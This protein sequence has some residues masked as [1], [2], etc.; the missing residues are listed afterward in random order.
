MR[1]NTIFYFILKTSG[2]LTNGVLTN[3]SLFLK[4]K[5]LSKKSFGQL[6]IGVKLSIS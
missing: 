3:F 5:N 1:E 4:E 6:V 2:K